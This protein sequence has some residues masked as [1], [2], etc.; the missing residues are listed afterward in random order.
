M[1]S[2]VPSPIS[3]K[4]CSTVSNAKSIV[5]ISET[6]RSFMNS[7]KMCSPCERSFAVAVGVD[8]KDIQK[9]LRYCVS[10]EVPVIAYRSKLTS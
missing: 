6:S 9:W 3:R 7:G 1:L 5:S 8:L 10:N 2:A 4:A